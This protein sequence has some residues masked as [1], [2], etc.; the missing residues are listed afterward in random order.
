MA[1]KQ[2]ITDLFVAEIKN[3]PMYA[4]ILAIK[5]HIIDTITAPAI[6]KNINYNFE[7]PLS[8]EQQENLKLCSLV[9]FG[10]VLD[11][12]ATFVIIDMMKFLDRNEQ[13]SQVI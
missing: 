7:T 13:L 9:E 6:Q 5:Q 3:D 12:N 10:F 2:E 1:S 4:I 11:I 8:N